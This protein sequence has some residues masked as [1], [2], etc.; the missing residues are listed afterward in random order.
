MR[1]R[2]QL[3]LVSL[4]TL[5]LPWAGCQ[6]VREFESALRQ[7][8]QDS[9]ADGAGA[10]AA[11]L[12]ARPNLLVRDPVQLV[13]GDDTATSG[14]YAVKL[15]SFVT[16][17]GFVA[18]WDLAA[19]DF[20]VIDEPIS[21]R[22]A[23]GLDQS[24]AWLYVEVS[25]NH[26]VYESP[27]GGRGDHVLI[28]Y[29][30]S[31]GQSKQLLVATAAR[32]RG[33]VRRRQDTRWVNEPQAQAVWEENSN[34]Y[35]VE[36]RLR[37]RLIGARLGLTIVDADP[38]GATRR[39]SSYR[40]I[41][42]GMFMHRL[43]SLEDALQDF[44]FGNRR[45]VVTDPAGWVIAAVGDTRSLTGAR[46]YPLLE[47]LLRKIISPGREPDPLRE[48]RQGQ[49]RSTEI[50]SAL[51][52]QADA[53]W[54]SA[55]DQRTAIVVAAH[56]IAV[57]G[58]LR[59]AVVLEQTSDAILTLTDR[60]L[61]RLLL[62]TL[63]ATLI[64]AAGL[65]GFATYLSI[66][67]QRLS[68]A[69]ERAVTPDGII[70]S[71]LP[72]TAAADELGDLSRNFAGL[73]GRL[74]EHTDYLRTLASKLSH[75]LRTPLAVV[76]SSLDNMEA[77]GLP[78]NTRVYAERAREGSQRL[79]SILTAMSE[80]SR[81]EQAIAS[82]D[83]ELFDLRALVEGCFNGY[84]DVH[85]DRRFVLELPSQ[86]AMIAGV[87]ELIAQML[88]KLVDNAVDFSPDNG[89]I[90]MSVLLEERAAQLSVANEGPSL[91]QTM[92]SQ[93]FDSMVSLRQSK[94]A[95]PHLG[96]GLHIARL[97]AESHEGSISCRNLP[98]D[99]GVVFTVT[100]PLNRAGAA[101]E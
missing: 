99:A 94:G 2:T 72:G 54:Y 40:G 61:T 90:E 17:D 69:A 68:R 11:M 71:E 80:A 41:R 92:Q 30:D 33:G 76:Q 55:V 86:Q 67:I 8:Q 58:R 51:N 19:D 81:V 21:L 7:S 24:N 1:L 98:A 27:D 75:E 59:G 93:I 101:G 65:L 16:L 14:I 100:L 44:G 60:A 46:A 9:L 26:V 96:F 38:D 12:A 89:R 74:G 48:A 43:Q 42:P 78:E 88:D 66:R 20:H 62:L 97:I 63:F 83:I 5:A 85:T 15:P 37:D 25:D 34:G 77:T 47:K 6:Y 39:A 64:A 10:I 32:G 3:L 56:P 53:R 35:Q 91:P 79:R 45:I 36:I 49:L 52:G 29:E 28:D 84:R 13:A 22:Y 73:L 23:A 4:L 18:D 70:S 50:T 95:E 82:A 87:P 31:A 57:D